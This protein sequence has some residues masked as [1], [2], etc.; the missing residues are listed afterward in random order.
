MNLGLF[1]VNFWGWNRAWELPLWSCLLLNVLATVQALIKGISPDQNTFGLHLPLHSHLHQ[2]FLNQFSDSDSTANQMR[3]L[4]SVLK[5]RLSSD[6]S[7]SIWS[8]SSRPTSNIDTAC[9]FNPTERFP[10][11]KRAARPAS[12]I[13]ATYSFRKRISNC[14]LN[15]DFSFAG[16]SGESSKITTLKALN[17]NYSLFSWSRTWRDLKIIIFWSRR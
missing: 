15:P 13:R 6:I 16:Q 10:I 12:Y 8:C 7:D 1:Q 9:F 11:I 14:W 4:E 3:A 5:T 2:Y 17:P